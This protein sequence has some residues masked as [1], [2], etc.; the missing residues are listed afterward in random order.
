MTSKKNTGESAAYEEQSLSTSMLA[1]LE[2][3]TNEIDRSILSSNHPRTGITLRAAAKL[4]SALRV[5][6]ANLLHES[7][8]PDMINQRAFNGEQKQQVS[9]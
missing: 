8:K 6:A 9:Y 3:A 5:M 2:S 4:K 1:C 7:K